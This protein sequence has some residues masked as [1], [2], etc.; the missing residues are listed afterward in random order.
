VMLKNKSY[1]KKSIGDEAGSAA[2]KGV[3]TSTNRGKVY[4]NSWSM[5]VKF[6]GE[7]VVR[8]LDLTTHNHMSPL[9]NTP[10][11]LY[12]DMMAFD[13]SGGKVCEDEKKEAEEKCR[14]AK[15]RPKR[16]TEAGNLVDDGL[17]C[18]AGCAEAKACVLK[19]KNE[20]KQSCCHPDTTG[21][22]LIE[23]H[24]FSPTGERG[25]Q[26]EDLDSYRQNDAPCVCASESRS[27]GTHG[28]L[29]AVQ[30]KIEGAYNDLPGEPFCEWLDAGPKVKGKKRRANAIS[31]WK[32]KDARDT[33]M[34]AHKTAFPKCNAM[35]I[36]KQLDD[37]HKD[38]CGF[39]DETPLRSDPGAEKRSSGTLEPDQETAID[40]AVFAVKGITSATGS[41]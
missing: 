22:H 29:H 12:Q 9:A 28:I 13:K 38:K 30:S 4:F 40:D 5:D 18:P 33:G 8:H 6:E 11:W 34:L 23:V 3:V 31:K 27:D 41:V 35:C 7:N 26:L 10:P 15:P 20:D 14:E 32:Y 19:P 25:G 16:K 1:F 2:K 17:D 37:Y 24:C 36:K 39:D 21:H